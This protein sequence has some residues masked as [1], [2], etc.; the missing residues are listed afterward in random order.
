MKTYRICAVITRPD[1]QA[2]R[3]AEPLA[4]LFELRLD[5]LG[6]SWVEIS[7]DMRKPW[8]A[9]NRLKSEGG[10]WE[11]SEETRIAELL[12]ATTLGADVVDIELASPG[13]KEIVPQIKKH[14]KCLIS[15][16][17]MKRTPKRPIL[18]KIV[19]AQ[20]SAGA[21]I[22]KVV[23]TANTARD[24]LN[25]LV[26]LRENPRVQLIS[27]TMGKEGQ[28]S[29]IFCPC[30]GSYLTYGALGEGHESADGQLSVALLRRAHE[31]M[32]S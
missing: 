6:A 5:L 25:A 27:F 17:D 12:K 26:L 3:Q 20:L 15:H 11:G 18:Q 13:L 21:D 14:A 30:F 19:D 23:T 4:D 8:I 28:T 10:A 31:M 9:T 24:S 16:H 32:R 2:I 22:C 7:K 29:R 1:Q